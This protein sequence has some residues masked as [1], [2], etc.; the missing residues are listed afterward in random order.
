MLHRW[1]VFCS[2]PIVK[3]C[4]V[5]LTQVNVKKESSDEGKSRYNL[6]RKQ[7]APLTITEIDSETDSEKDQDQCGQSKSD[8]EDEDYNFRNPESNS[9]T[10]EEEDLDHT[11]SGSKFNTQHVSQPFNLL[12]VPQELNL[13]DQMN[14]RNICRPQNIT[15][16]AQVRNDESLCREQYRPQGRIPKDA[17][18]RPLYR[19]QVNTLTG[20][21]SYYRPSYTGKFISHQTYRRQV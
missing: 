16:H 8:A 14:Q 6:R 1:A 11:V 12:I 7:M 5:R 9:D 10:S 2:E 17:N 20:A 4:F 3:P 15:P 13:V 18:G 21:I 19:P